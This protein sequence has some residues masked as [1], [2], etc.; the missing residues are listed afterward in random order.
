MFFTVALLELSEEIRE[1]IQ[2]RLCGSFQVLLD[3]FDQVLRLVVNC[4]EHE[5]F[6]FGCLRARFAPFLHDEG[7]FGPGAFH[8][9]ILFMFWIVFS[10][11]CHQCVDDT[12]NLDADI[13]IHEFLIIQVRVELLSGI[14]FYCGIIIYRMCN[15]PSSLRESV[16]SK[17]IRTFGQVPGP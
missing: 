7:V 4:L 2:P 5:W 14:F 13:R 16:A 9:R 12:G 6:R 10:S 8:L 11:L 1:V 3:V 15:D 17:L